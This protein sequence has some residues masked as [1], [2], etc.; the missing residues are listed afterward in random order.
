MAKRQGIPKKKSKYPEKIKLTKSMRRMFREMRTRHMTELNQGVRDVYEDLGLSERVENQQETGEIF[1][2]SQD[3]SYIVITNK[4]EPDGKD[5]D[6]NE[7]EPDKTEE[8][9]T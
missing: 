5:G 8:S 7:E 9:N 1:E 4:P 3:F 6:K 2:V